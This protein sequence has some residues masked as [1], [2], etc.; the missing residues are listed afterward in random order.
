MYSD[1]LS[2]AG[3]LWVLKS[4]HCMY[5]VAM[6]V[7]FQDGSRLFTAERRRVILA[8]LSLSSN[9]ALPFEVLPALVEVSHRK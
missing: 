2:S 3:H 1:M 5:R 6:S 9:V 7:P 4:E 8:S